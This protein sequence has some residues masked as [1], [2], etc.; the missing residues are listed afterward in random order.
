LAA[1]EAQVEGY[2][3]LACDTDLAVHVDGARDWTPWAIEGVPSPGYP[4]GT[5][6]RCWV[7]AF[8]RDCEVTH[9][10]A[11]VARENGDASEYLWTDDAETTTDVVPTLTNVRV[12]S[13][14]SSHHLPL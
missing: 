11:L 6:E 2:R 9:P 10:S 4:D 8:G 12:D 14:S 3:M 5:T 1:F 13:R 7:L